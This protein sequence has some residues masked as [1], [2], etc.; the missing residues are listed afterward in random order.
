M[1]DDT[2]KPKPINW[3][4]VWAYFKYLEFM[5]GRKMPDGFLADLKLQNR[6]AQ[7]AHPQV[8]DESTV[9][10][11]SQAQAEAGD[12]GAGDESSDTTPVEKEVGGD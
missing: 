5:T 4:R 12:Q 6:L 10:P 3:A 2:N 8:P 11:E 1:S 9:P 7:A